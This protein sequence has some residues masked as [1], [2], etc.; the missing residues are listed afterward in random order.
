M[1]IQYVIEALTFVVNKRTCPLTVT[2]SCQSGAVRQLEEE[3]RWQLGLFFSFIYFFV[4]FSLKWILQ[5]DSRA[6][7][8][9]DGEAVCA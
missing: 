1:S 8:R 4:Y 5:G 9:E 3:S 6:S 7:V 2:Q